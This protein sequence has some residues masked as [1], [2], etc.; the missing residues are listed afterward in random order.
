MKASSV[1][2]S[3]SDPGVHEPHTVDP[4]REFLRRTILFEGGIV[5]DSATGLE[6]L[7]PPHAAQRLAV[8]EELDI[9]LSPSDPTAAADVVDGR[10]GSAL[11]ERWVAQRLERPTI[12]AVELPA[13][14]P[15]PLPDGMPIL[16]NAVRAGDAER[17]R[18][19]ARYLVAE[20]RVTLQG[21]ELRSTIAPLAIRLDDGARTLPPSMA[22]AYPVA[23]PALDG[24]ERENAQAALRAWLWREGPALHAGALQTLRRRATRDLDRL[25]EY[26]AGLNSEM[27]QAVERARG[28]DERGRRYAKWAALRVDLEARREQVRVRLRPRLAGAIIAATLV[29]CDVDEFDFGVR[30]RKREGTVTL[31][32]RAADGVFEGPACAACRT[33]ALRLYLC[34]EHLHVLCEACGQ[35]GRL[36][37]ARCGACHGARAEPPRIVLED[38]TSRLTIGPAGAEARSG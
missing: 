35:P 21:D 10:I 34:D 2:S 20:V 16:L 18:V 7:L 17:R 26:Y 29:Q 15:T 32:C 27:A 3:A 6:A 24:R 1:T 22:G 37:R 5:D 9:H 13:G 33:S 4:A 11:L 28:D 25:A 12:A 31:R 36:D 30:R 19:R 23:A 38:P 8:R 14:L